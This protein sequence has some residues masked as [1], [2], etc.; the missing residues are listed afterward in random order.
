MSGE[1]K[2]DRDLFDLCLTDPGVTVLP[3]GTPLGAV[4]AET[5][6]V[7]RLLV[8]LHIYIYCRKMAVSIRVVGGRVK[9]LACIDTLR[10]NLTSW[11][12]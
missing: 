6:H 1:T 4:D 8:D 10:R 11:Y 5:V 12:Y 9:K 3:E 2:D 7:C